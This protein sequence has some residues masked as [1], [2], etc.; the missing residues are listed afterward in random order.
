QL[1]NS[2]KNILD[3]NVDNLPIDVNLNTDIIENSYIRKNINLDMNR[4]NLI[5]TINKISDYV[6]EILDVNKNN[7]NLLLNSNNP[8]FYVLNGKNLVS[9]GYKEFK[10]KPNDREFLKTIDL[11]PVFDKYPEGTKYS[12]SF[13]IKTIDNTNSNSIIVYSQNGSGSYYDINRNIMSVEKDYERKKLENILPVKWMENEKQAFLS[14]YGSYGT[15]NYPIV[16]NIKVEIG[17]KATEYRMSP[18]DKFISQ[19]PYSK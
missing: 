3:C 10:N 19:Y 5:K 14:F 4:T 18:E 6:N 16:K 9:G 11:K 15:N 2:G 12:I 13:D 17:S 8:S 7:E 1:I